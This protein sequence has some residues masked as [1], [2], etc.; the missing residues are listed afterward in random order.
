VAQF[1]RAF[2]KGE[3]PPAISDHLPRGLQRYLREL[4]LA[5]GGTAKFFKLVPCAVEAVRMRFCGTA[6]S[7][8]SD[9][10]L[11]DLEQFDNTRPV[12]GFL[13][14][15]ATGGE[16]VLPQRLP[17]GAGRFLKQ[18]WA[19][20]KEGKIPP[21]LL[22]D[23][24]EDCL[25]A[26]LGY[27]DLEPDA[28]SALAAIGAT[29]GS[30]S[31]V[32]AFLRAIAAGEDPAVPADLARPAESLLVRV[33]LSAR[34]AGVQ[35]PRTLDIIAVGFG[36]PATGV[37]LFALAHDLVA[38]A[39]QVSK[40]P[41]RAE[42]AIQRF[43]AA[44]PER[45]VVAQRLRSLVTQE[46]TTAPAGTLPVAL[47]LLLA[48]LDALAKSEPIP[49]DPSLVGLAAIRSRYGGGAMGDCIMFSLRAL[50]LAGPEYAA[51]MKY[52]WSIARGGPAGPAPSMTNP[53]AAETAEEVRCLADP[54]VG[55]MRLIMAPARQHADSP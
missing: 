48:Q 40:V 54:E 20:V 29:G 50:G 15:L 6:F 5:A 42:R 17:P 10:V 14:D 34:L 28:L 41:P 1:V 39:E 16:S 2:A 13:R 51:L 4:S 55:G 19:W 33:S 37:D 35:Q 26:R 27:G 22:G 45:T 38:M 49:L 23:V 53:H 43:E 32:A 25:K 36:D 30:W 47:R 52:L 9:A 8:E 7:Q 21:G 46:P 3:D 18:T 44:A 12:A 24:A 11:A 31:S